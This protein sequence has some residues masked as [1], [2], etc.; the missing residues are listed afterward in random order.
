MCL[1][2]VHLIQPQHQNTA[3]TSREETLS[4]DRSTH[5]MYSR[6]PTI[7]FHIPYVIE[8]DASRFLC[9][10]SSLAYQQY[11]KKVLSLR[12]N[13]GSDGDENTGAAE[14]D[15]NDHNADNGYGGKHVSDAAATAGA[16][17]P[18][19]IDAVQP[20]AE[21]TGGDDRATTTTDDKYD[22]ADMYEDDD[23]DQQH[24][25]NA[26]GDGPDDN[27]NNAGVGFDQALHA[28]GSGYDSDSEYM[29]ETMSRNFGQQLKR[30][31]DID[32]RQ[33]MPF[34]GPSGRDAMDGGG[35]P[36]G[37]DGGTGCGGGSSDEDDGDGGAANASADGMSEAQRKKR[38]RW[39]D[40]VHSAVG[41]ARPPQ[42]QQRIN[43]F[44]TGGVGGPSS[45]SAC[46]AMVPMLTHC[47]RTNPALLAYARQS[48]GTIELDDETWRKCEDHFKVNLLY[49]D[50]LRK[51]NEIDRLARAGRQKYE[52]D[53]DEDVQGGTWEHKARNA[54][55]EATAVW[56]DALTKQAEGKHHI[57]DFLPPEELRKFMEKYESQ[58]T[59]RAPDLSDYREYKLREDNKGGR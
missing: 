58:Q 32:E 19:E 34:G 27:D 37:D 2:N 51:R 28:D 45:S 21:Q 15:D 6:Y 30:K 38:S 17:R 39:G 20:F 4:I 41:S 56:S 10:R 29:R 31:L 53:S 3:R 52:Y 25:A 16:S 11:R 23:D 12:Y 8:S 35:G 36:T 7:L 44:A 26:H 50:M 22:P 14:E 40:K 24:H 1:L 48:Y 47:T 55:M 5:L 57:G 59:N 49:Q 13:T 42:P 54:E 33:L 9:D 46:A 18:Y 43:P